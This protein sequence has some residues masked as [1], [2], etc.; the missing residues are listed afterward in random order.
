MNYFGATV[1]FG[2]SKDEIQKNLK[3]KYNDA[4]VKILVSAFGST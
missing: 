3:Q 2:S 1:Q 4:G